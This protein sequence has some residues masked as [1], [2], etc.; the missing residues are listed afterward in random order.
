[1]VDTKELPFRGPREVEAFLPSFD[2]EVLNER[3]IKAEERLRQLFDE[4]LMSIM[5]EL[6][7]DAKMKQYAEYLAIVSFFDEFKGVHFGFS[8]KNQLVKT[9][10]V[11]DGRDVGGF[12]GLTDVAIGMKHGGL[13]ESDRAGVRD[14]WLFNK[15]LNYRRVRFDYSITVGEDHP[16][17]KYP[18]RVIKHNSAPDTIYLGE[19]KKEEL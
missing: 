19:I 8:P 2:Q 11:M 10:F 17:A 12:T 14:L 13:K 9:V 1:M 16:A 3:K 5:P 4:Q 7:F 15:K 18:E 6:E